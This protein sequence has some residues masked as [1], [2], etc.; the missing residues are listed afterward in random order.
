MGKPGGRSQPLFRRFFIWLFAVSLAAL[1]L[2]LVILVWRQ[3]NPQEVDGNQY[4]PLR[5]PVGAQVEITP[6]SP[7]A[8]Q[9]DEMCTFHKCFNVYECG[10]NDQTRISLYVYPLQQVGYC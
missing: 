7:V 3:E 10:Y 5:V 6:D 2:A 8:R 1:I 9:R 4:Q